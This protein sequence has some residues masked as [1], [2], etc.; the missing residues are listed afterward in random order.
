MFEAL[1]LLLVYSFFGEYTKKKTFKSNLVL[2]QGVQLI[3]RISR[4]TTPVSFLTVYTVCLQYPD[5]THKYSEQF[6][7][8]VKKLKKQNQGRWHL[9]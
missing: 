6:E 3:S 9:Q 8:N 5:A 1:S 7:Y 4:T 2:E